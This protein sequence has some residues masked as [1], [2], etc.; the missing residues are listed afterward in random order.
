MCSWVQQSHYAVIHSRCVTKTVLSRA[1]KVAGCSSG[2]SAST[3]PLIRRDTRPSHTLHCTAACGENIVLWTHLTKI[4]PVLLMQLVTIMVRIYYRGWEALHNGRKCEVWVAEKRLEKKEEG[5]RRK[6][7]CHVMIY[8]FQIVFLIVRNWLIKSW[9][10]IEDKSCW[11]S[12]IWQN[13]ADITITRPSPRHSTAQL[14]ACN[15]QY[16]LRIW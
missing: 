12:I 3:S 16:K 8:L 9:S 4:L 5:S 1:E 2:S 14:S 7:P 6:V 10:V 11:V 13:A 15:T